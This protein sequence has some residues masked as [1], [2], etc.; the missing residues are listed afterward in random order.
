MTIMALCLRI[1]S[2]AMKVYAI[3]GAQRGGLGPEDAGHLSLSRRANDKLPPGV[4]EAV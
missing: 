1:M 2:I 3:P 4:P